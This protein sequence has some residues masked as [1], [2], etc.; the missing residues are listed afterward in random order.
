MTNGDRTLLGVIMDRMMHADDAKQAAEQRRDRAEEAAELVFGELV[1]AK[2]RI[3]ELE[4][5]L[6]EQQQ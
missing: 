6:K 5:Q 1:A 2:E 3:R 4:A